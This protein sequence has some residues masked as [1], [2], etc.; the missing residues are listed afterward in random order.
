MNLKLKSYYYQSK[1]H[2]EKISLSNSKIIAA[3]RD[4]FYETVHSNTFSF[5]QNKLQEVLR[6]YQK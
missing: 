6:K 2:R 5:D 4:Y 3:F 1:N